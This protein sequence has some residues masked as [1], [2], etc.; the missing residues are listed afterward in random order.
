VLFFLL[1]QTYP[2]QH[3]HNKFRLGITGKPYAMIISGWWIPYGVMLSLFSIGLLWSVVFFIAP[4]SAK[5]DAAAAYFGKVA[6]LLQ[7]MLYLILYVWMILV[8]L[9]LFLLTDHPRFWKL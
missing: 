9:R 1:S 7:R 2:V 3:D 6:G 5:I 8:G 4:A